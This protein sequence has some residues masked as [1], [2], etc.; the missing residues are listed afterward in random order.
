MELLPLFDQAVHEFT[1]RVDSVGASDWDK[2]TPCREWTVRQLV[3]HLVDEHRWIPPLMGGHDLHTAQQIV[4]SQA[5]ASAG[6]TA[7]DWHAAST[8]SMQ[9][10]ADPD[11]LERTVELSRGPTPAQQ[12]LMEMMF[13]LVVHGWDLG[14]AI[15]YPEQMPD[16]LVE[17][18]L[19]AATA[20]ADEL[21]GSGMFDPP[22]EI[23]A[24]A[25]TADQ[26][27]AL[28]GRDPR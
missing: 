10:L 12:Y 2:P 9:A 6:D 25:S 21:A 24:G 8:A 23:G 3:E 15:G 7:E 18:T 14:R 26:L 17:P 4:A 27:A 16:A 5:E 20:M 1:T 11:A 19:H 28:T 22:V 13:D